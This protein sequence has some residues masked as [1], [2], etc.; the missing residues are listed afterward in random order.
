MAVDDWLYALQFEV[1]AQS[2]RASGTRVGSAVNDSRERFAAA[3]QRT[4]ESVG[5][6]RGGARAGDGARKVAGFLAE[7]PVLNATSDAVRLQNCVDLLAADVR[8][9]PTPLR[10]VQ[11]AEAIENTRRDLVL[12][13]FARVVSSPAG[14]A[15]AAGVRAI[16]ALGGDSG[17]PLVER[18]IR[19]THRLVVGKR[20]PVEFEDLLALARAYLLAGKPGIAAHYA[21]K[22]AD[23]TRTARFALAPVK[24]TTTVERLS[25]GWNREGARGVLSAASVTVGET[26]ARIDAHFT[27]DLDRLDPYTR[28]RK[29]EGAAWTVAAWAYRELGDRR[30]AEQLARQAIELGFSCGYEV[31][32]AVIEPE[33]WFGKRVKLRMDAMDEVDRVDRAYYRGHVRGGI[34]TSGATAAEQAGKTGRLVRRLLP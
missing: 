4:H 30:S 34:R 9:E 29:Q 5:Q 23:L 21:L 2:V 22:A 10:V 24:R 3:L 17:P 27:G 26:A 25:R 13:R 12:T 14:V 19:H 7:F 8:N 16:T 15:T 28:A 20:Q 11:L 31:Q 1:E 33:G 32:A 6:T 18:L